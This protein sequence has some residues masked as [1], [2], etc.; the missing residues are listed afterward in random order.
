MAWVSGDYAYLARN[1]TLIILDVRDPARPV[2]RSSYPMPQGSTPS[3]VKVAGGLAYVACHDVGGGPNKGGL[4]I[5][6]VA[7][8][9]SA[10]SRRRSAAADNGSSPMTRC[11]RSIRRER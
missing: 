4:Q 7:N 10:A 3:A 8:P 1:H 9:R 6:N 5:V 11:R 2:F